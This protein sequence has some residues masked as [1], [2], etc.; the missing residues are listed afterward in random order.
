[1]FTVP[2]HMLGSSRP[3]CSPE[4]MQ[5]FRQVA[6]VQTAAML[7]LPRPKLDGEKPA[8]RHAL[9][10]PELKAVRAELAARAERFEKP[11]ASI[12]AK[13]TC[14]RLRRRGGRRALDLAPDETDRPGRAPEQG[15][16]GCRKS[17]FRHLAG[18]QI[19]NVLPNWCSATVHAKD[20]GSRFYRD[21]AE[22]LEALWLPGG[23]IAFI[24]DT[25]LMHQSWRCSVTF[26]QQGSHPVWQHA[27]DGSGTS[28]QERLMRFT[29]SMLR[30]GRR[31]WSNAKD[32]SS[33]RETRT[34]SSGFP[35]TSPKGSFDAYMWQTL[36][37]KAKF[38]AQVMSGD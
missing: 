27:K 16:P 6:D 18:H 37:T 20:R 8:I 9:A 15:Q 4:L 12:R 35:F 31:I 21:V 1:M 22:K 24:Q 19:R 11:V 26:A 33:G 5:M 34:P 3:N 25:T 23:D 29:I 30:G 10:T 2:N 38:I 7:D 28:V 17:I 36:E 32:A 13:T 14:S